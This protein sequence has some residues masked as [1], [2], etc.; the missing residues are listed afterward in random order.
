MTR[1]EYVD[2]LREGGLD[3]AN[4]P[5]T[6][7]RMRAH[8]ERAFHE[9]QSLTDEAAG[10]YADV[11]DTVRNMIGTDVDSLVLTAQDKEAWDNP[12]LNETSALIS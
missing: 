9:L 4:S 1:A 11:V 3:K 6:E 7:E 5:A 2:A 12:K 8:A 10:E